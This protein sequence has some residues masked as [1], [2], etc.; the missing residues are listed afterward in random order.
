MSSRLRNNRYKTSRNREVYT[1]I[2]FNFGFC[3]STFIIWSGSFMFSVCMDSI[4]SRTDIFE[5][6]MTRQG[7]KNGRWRRDD[8]HNIVQSLLLFSIYT[9]TVFIVSWILG[10]ASDWVRHIIVPIEKERTTIE[11]KSQAVIW[12]SE[13]STLSNHIV[14]ACLWC[15]IVFLSHLSYW[16]H[17]PILRLEISILGYTSCIISQ[18]LCKSTSQEFSIPS[19]S[20]QLLWRK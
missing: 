15:S 2:V 9:Y 18:V 17:R 4:S 13:N 7:Y 8:S 5:K 10:W 1:L 16:Y 3:L 14:S 12:N 6:S 11:W 19:T 20:Y